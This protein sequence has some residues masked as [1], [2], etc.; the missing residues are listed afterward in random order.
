MSQEDGQKIKE[1]YLEEK[2]SFCFVVHDLEGL[3]DIRKLLTTLKDIKKYFEHWIII[4]SALQS[5]LIGKQSQLYKD[6]LWIFYL[7]YRNICTEMHKH[8]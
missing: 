8:S 1:G 7:H 2:N 4:D 5:L 6:V 3:L